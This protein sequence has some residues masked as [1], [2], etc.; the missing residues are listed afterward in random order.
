M[1]CCYGGGVERGTLIPEIL[2]PKKVKNGKVGSTKWAQGAG[3]RKSYQLAGVT[4]LLPD[5]FLIE[6]DVFRA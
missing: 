3:S 1:P 5:Y 6:R 4:W 2:L